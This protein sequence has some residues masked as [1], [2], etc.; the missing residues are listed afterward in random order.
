[1]IVGFGLFI[2]GALA[3]YFFTLLSLG[4]IPFWSFGGPVAV[5]GVVVFLIGCVLA[6]VAWFR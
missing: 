6:A 1:M 3:G 4:T 2:I 5:L